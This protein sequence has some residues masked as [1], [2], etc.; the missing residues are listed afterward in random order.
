M[1]KNEENDDL[2]FCFANSHTLAIIT[3]IRKNNERIQLNSDIVTVQGN[4]QERKTGK[5]YVYV[6]YTKRKKLA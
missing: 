3:I 6:Q 5:L 4:I 1:E 2:F